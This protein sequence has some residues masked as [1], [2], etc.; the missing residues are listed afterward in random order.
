MTNAYADTGV[1]GTTPKT[2]ELSE[3]GTATNTSKKPATDATEAVAAVGSPATDKSALAKQPS[4][5]V[6]M[7]ASTPPPAKQWIDGFDNQT[8]M[9]AAGGAL[10]LLVLMK[11][12][13]GA[14]AAQTQF[15]PMPSYR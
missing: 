6:D 5:D 10:V 12:K 11:S 1:G 3:V 9:L 7:K 4:L 13:G 14:G 15:I 2:T 8:V